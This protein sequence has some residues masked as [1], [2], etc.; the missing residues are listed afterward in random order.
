MF[1]SRVLAAGA[2]S[3]AAFA[4]L[5]VATAMAA[6]PAP[7]NNAPQITDPKADGHHAR[8]DVLAAWLTESAGRLQAV[9][10]VDNAVWEPAH[11]DSDAAGLALIYEQGGQ[12]RYARVVVPRGALPT[13]DVGTW[14]SAGGFASAGAVTGTVTSGVGG[15]ATI[16]VPAVTAGTVLARPF[17][18]TYDGFDSPGAPH[19]V[20]RAPGGVTVSE[21]AYGADFVAGACNAGTVTPPGAPP[22]PGGATQPGTVRTTAIDLKAPRKLTGT[23]RAKI[24]GRVTPARAG[25]AVDITITGR[26]PVV[27]RATTAADG[28]F[29][30]SASVSETSTVRAV[31]EGLGSQTLTVK[32]QSRVRIKIRRLKSGTVVVSGTTSP[33]LSGRVLLLRTNAVKAT[34]RTTARNGRFQLRLKSP[35]RGRYEVVFIPSGDRAERSTS[36]TGVIR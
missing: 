21:A 36:N 24:T 23:Q 35:K 20:D 18:L 12:M 30:V 10:Q 27:R 9:I 25:V 29:S 19:W 5:P 14:T 4:A 26:T 11:D 7:C 31:A 3:L 33:K 16:D 15:A 34:A 28:T 17:V 2:S 13:F 8:S 6:P 32:M 22:V 1:R